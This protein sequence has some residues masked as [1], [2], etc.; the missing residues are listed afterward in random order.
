MTETVSRLDRRKAKTRSA[1]IAAA[2]QLLAENRTEASIQQVTELA[3]VGFGTF[4]N[5]FTDKAEL[6]RAAIYDVLQGHADLV[7]TASAGIADPAEVFC[8]GM[9]LTGRLARAMPQMARVL[10]HFGWQYLLDESG[11]SSH[12][13][14]DLQAAIDSGRFDVTDVDVALV[15]TGGAMLGL[16][17]LLDS[18]ESLDGGALADEFAGRILRALGLTKSEARQ[19]VARPLPELPLPTP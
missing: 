8:V 2:Q 14:H 12:V 13:R 5:H 3:D 19:L 18:D 1:L 6:W 16:V 17:T 9:R 11:M 7:A 4:Y 15:L 10:I